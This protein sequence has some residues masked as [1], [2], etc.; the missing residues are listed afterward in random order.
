MGIELAFYSSEYNDRTGLCGGLSLSSAVS[1]FLGNGLDFETI[2][3]PGMGEG[4]LKVYS[5]HY[6]SITGYDANTGIESVS[7]CLLA[8]NSNSTTYFAVPTTSGQYI[9]NGSHH[10]GGDDIPT[11]VSGEAP[12]FISANGWGEALEILSGLVST[13]EDSSASFG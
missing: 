3:S 10:Y 8:S 5:R 9:S 12:E 4:K 1:G 11:W 2:T 7:V 13:G 6:V